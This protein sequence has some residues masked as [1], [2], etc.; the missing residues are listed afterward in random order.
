MNKIRAIDARILAQFQGFCD[1]LTK[2]FGMTE[3]PYK[4]ANIVLVIIPVIV[5]ILEIYEYFSLPNKSFAGCICILVLYICLGLL[6]KHRIE[7]E[8]NS[9]RQNT[10]EERTLK[11][12]EKFF[13][14]RCFYYSSLFLWTIITPI[15]RNIPRF[16][17]WTGEWVGGDSA[18]T[19]S[20][21]IYVW[22]FFFLFYGANLAVLYFLNCSSLPSTKSKVRVWWE[23]LALKL[24]FKPAK[25][26]T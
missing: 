21:I 10:G 25:Q 20:S 17:F 23:R 1:W 8:R 11:S 26:N 22:I 4:M 6:L 3:A 19:T 16:D 5:P 14:D 12:P 15:I 18:S 7:K 9:E 24:K 13:S 2:T